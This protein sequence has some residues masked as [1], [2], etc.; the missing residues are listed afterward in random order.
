[1]D[2]PGSTEDQARPRVPASPENSALSTSGSAR[3]ST[4]ECQDNVELEPRMDPQSLPRIST[5]SDHDLWKLATPGPTPIKDG[6]HIHEQN[7]A[8]L[9][10]TTTT[11]TSPAEDALTTAQQADILTPSPST[12]PASSVRAPSPLSF[13]NFPDRLGLREAGIATHFRLAQPFTRTRQT[14]RTITGKLSI[15]ASRGYPRTD[16]APTR[17]TKPSLRHRRYSV[18]VLTRNWDSDSRHGWK[19]EFPEVCTRFFMRKRTDRL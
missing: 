4:T 12:S 16:H 18:D 2:S 6:F 19:Q 5:D 7:D 15:I 10:T 1:M 3:S 11:I 9:A 13:A 17:P 14:M 8:S